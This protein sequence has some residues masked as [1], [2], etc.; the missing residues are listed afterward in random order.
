MS[1]RYE[2][3]QV[4][5]RPVRAAGTAEI[6]GRTVVVSGRR[7]KIAAIKDEDWLGAQSRSSPP[8][9]SSTRFGRAAFRRHFHVCRIICGRSSRLVFPFEWDNVAAIRTTDLKAWWDGLPQESR[10]NV[11]RAAKRG[12]K[13]KPVS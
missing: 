7:L 12:V 11:R 2:E 10:K 1:I 5:G 9:S 13:V 4:R 8:A 6:D 3:L